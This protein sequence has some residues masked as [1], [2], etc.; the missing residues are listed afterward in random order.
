MKTIK[1]LLI[2]VITA[3][4]WNSLSQTDLPN[5]YINL[6][7]GN[8]IPVIVQQSNGYAVQSFKPNKVS[9]RRFVCR[10]SEEGRYLN[11]GVFIEIM[12]P[13]EGGYAIQFCEPAEDV[14]ARNQRILK[15]TCHPGNVPRGHVGCP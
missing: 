2:T 13:S 8:F 1:T 3:F 11:E 7:E 6:L 4:S 10:Y 5:W 15:Q 14:E 9:T 12:P